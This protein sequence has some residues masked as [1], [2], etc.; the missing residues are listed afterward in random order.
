MLANLKKCHIVDMGT[1]E[2]TDLDSLWQQRQWYQLDNVSVLNEKITNAPYYVSPVG[3]SDMLISFNA[4]FDD[5][6]DEWKSRYPTTMDMEALLV[7]SH[8]LGGRILIEA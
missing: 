3:E 8:S 2:P 1:L 7:L 6:F 5:R 4:D